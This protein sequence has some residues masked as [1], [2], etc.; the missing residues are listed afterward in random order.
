MT[1]KNHPNRAINRTPKY[2]SAQDEKGIAVMGMACRFPGAKDY[3][4]FWR[5]L[6]AGVNSIVE[7]PKDRWDWRDYF[8][9]PRSEPNK[10]NSKWGGFVEDIDKFDASFFRTSP[11]EAEQMDP[12]Q[13]ILL[14]LTWGCLENSG[15]KPSAFVGRKVGVFIGVC[16]NDYKEIQENYGRSFEGYAASG[17]GGAILANRIS[18]FFNFQGPSIIVDTA[19]S[20][21]LISIHHAVNSING[22]EIEL[23]IAGGINYLGTATRH[24]ALSNLGMLSSTGRC[25]TFDKNADGYVRGEGA[26]LIFLK[27]LKQALDDNNRIFGVIKSSCMNHGG[28]VQ[29]LTAP[30]AYAQSKLIVDAYTKANI[31]PNTVTYLETHGTGT[32]LGDPIE[33][34]GLIRAFKKL[35]RQFGIKKPISPHCGLG[36]VKTNIGHLEGAAGIA[37]V[38]KILMAMKFNKLP[39]LQNFSTLNP[40]ISLKDSPFYIVHE[41]QGWKTLQDTQGKEIPRRAGVSSFGFGGANAHVVIEEYVDGEKIGSTRPKIEDKE[42]YLIVLSAKNKDRLKEAAKNLYNYLN[43]QIM[44]LTEVAYTLQ[45]GREAMEERISFI[46]TNKAELKAELTD[47]LDGHTHKGNCFRGNIKEDRNFLDLDTSDPD[48]IELIK[49]WLFK[50]KLRKIAKL[51]CKGLDID[52]SLLYS[53]SVPQRVSLPTYPF[54]RT[55]HWLSKAPPHLS[56]TRSCM[57]PL[58]DKIIPSM[59]AGVIFESRFSPS[60]PLVSHHRVEDRGM[61]PG[62]AYIEMIY[63]GL[64]EMSPGILI[65][66][67]EHTWIQPFC[68]EESVKN[69]QLKIEEVKDGFRYQFSSGDHQQ[70]RHSQGLVRIDHNKDGEAY[71]DIAK[72]RAGLAE[73]IDTPIAQES[74]YQKFE[75][76]GISYGEN[77]RCLHKLWANPDVAIAYLELPEKYLKDLNDYEIAPVLFDAALQSIA[78]TKQGTETRLFLPYSFDRLR[79]ISSLPRTI[80]SYVRKVGNYFYDITLVDEK[81]KVLIEVV[82]LRVR[83]LREQG[84]NYTYSQR[85]MR[86]PARTES[87]ARVKGNSLFVY[88]EPSYE[89]DRAIGFKDSY[90]I[91]IADKSEKISDRLHYV[92]AHE[93]DGISTILSELPAIESLYFLGGIISTES[94]HVVRELTQFEKALTLSFFRTVKALIQSGYEEKQLQITVITQDAPTE[95]WIIASIVS[96]QV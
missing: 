59:N 20:S 8:G 27:S 86:K 48:S 64:K 43:N 3:K 10:T 36:A 61:L 89:F 35:F 78:G 1:K 57:T 94:S 54:S 38:I 92:S 56:R 77:Y 25:Q 69:I 45:V 83:E 74:F 58:L 88:L 42:P 22:K 2:P 96:A 73:V 4:E 6:E 11:R 44:N 95:S 52:W 14:E 46:I 47:Y 75:R 32:P 65:E 79:R 13:R 15:Y 68:I 18:Y 91:C 33:I 23:A 55:R 37:G 67:L 72:L 39:A 76:A 51:W 87:T 80:F 50:K 70:I 63:E 62:T 81:G 53:E 9:N 5:N 17:T 71:L 93:K 21:S 84:K 24:M 60:H 85:W 66:L 49:K 34:N 90:R 28:S 40:R 29:T 26:G 82:H 31:P 30:S 16:H 41:T 7:I 12:Q 19:C